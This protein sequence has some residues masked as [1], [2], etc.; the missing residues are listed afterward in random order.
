[1]GYDGRTY[2]M[3]LAILACIRAFFSPRHAVYRLRRWTVP[4]GENIPTNWWGNGGALYEPNR[5]GT[6]L[7]RAGELG[8]VAPGALA[9]LLVVHG[10]PLADLTLLQGQGK[11]L[12]VI[13]KGGRLY[14]NELDG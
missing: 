4:E 13:M 5:P 3:A 1:M 9:D 8:V 11:H 12:Q 10:N 6:L 14:K 7:Q 2:P